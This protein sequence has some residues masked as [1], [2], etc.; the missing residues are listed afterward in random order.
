MF[1]I[2]IAVEFW[3]K[4]GYVN[5]NVNFVVSEMREHLVSCLENQKFYPFPKENEKSR[6]AAFSGI[7]KTLKI[8]TL[9]SCEMPEF[10]DSLVICENRKCR[11]R[12][13]MKCVGIKQ[14]NRRSVSGKSLDNWPWQCVFC[15]K[16]NN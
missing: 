3:F 1:A 10:V 14:V 2:A 8:K 5:T 6:S 16:I 13:H 4:N 11:K 9:C 15:N 7:P 12:F